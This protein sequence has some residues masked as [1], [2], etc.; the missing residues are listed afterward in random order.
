LNRIIVSGCGQFQGG[1]GV[2]PLLEAAGLP[3]R[4]VLFADGPA[5]RRAGGFSIYC[6]HGWF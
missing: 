4:Q 5:P 3:L 1:L 6:F 2:Q